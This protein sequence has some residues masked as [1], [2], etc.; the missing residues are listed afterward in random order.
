[1]VRGMVSECLALERVHPPSGLPCLPRRL[2]V[3]TQGTL[4][5]GFLSGWFT[6]AG[7]CGHMGQSGGPGEDIVLSGKM[8]W[9][10]SPWSVDGLVLWVL[11]LFLGVTGALSS[12]RG[13]QEGRDGFGLAQ[14]CLGSW[15][16]SL[17]PTC[18]QA[19][20]TPPRHLPP[21]TQH[22]DLPCET[23]Y[24]GR[25]AGG[26]LLRWPHSGLGVGV[27]A[28]GHSPWSPRRCSSFLGSEMPQ[29]WLGG[30]GV[31]RRDKDVWDGVPGPWV[32]PLGGVGVMRRGEAASD[33]PGCQQAQRRPPQARCGIPVV[34]AQDTRRGQ[35]WDRGCLLSGLE[36][37]VK[38][39]GARSS[40]GSGV[41]RSQA[42]PSPFSVSAV[43]SPSPP[44]V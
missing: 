9:T 2:D 31:G 34:P 32:L 11:R 43:T 12:L 14:L 25:G 44:C 28:C 6:E 41:S 10:L 13:V 33:G 4:E 26:S 29:G 5:G 36:P 42:T 27:V 40:M 37:E 24:L 16:G 38:M 15:G 18:S 19:L 30:G 17:W 3:L 35:G 1:M 8:R 23:G 22:K 7:C 20:V 39:L 21:G